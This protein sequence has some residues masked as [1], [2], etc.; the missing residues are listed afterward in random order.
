[1]TY[2]HCFNVNTISF[3]KTIT[4]QIK[5][6]IKKKNEPK[7]KE[8]NHSLNYAHDNHQEEQ[9]SKDKSNNNHNLQRLD[10]FIKFL[11]TKVDGYRVHTHLYRNYLNRS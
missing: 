6:I 10:I 8:G 4:S 9:N 11:E 7:S 5:I 1:M 2:C 3:L